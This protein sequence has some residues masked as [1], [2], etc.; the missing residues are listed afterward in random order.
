MTLTT[1][2]Q[3]RER[4]SESGSTRSQWDRWESKAKRNRELELVAVVITT[5]ELVG[6]L[7]EVR[8][9]EELI[10]R[11]RGLGWQMVKSCLDHDLEMLRNCARQ[12]ERLGQ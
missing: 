10:E 9:L 8:R 6:I 2:R 4:M 12:V 1:V 7:E 3:K 5:D 11:A